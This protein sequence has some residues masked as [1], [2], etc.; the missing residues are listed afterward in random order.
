MTRILRF[1]LLFAACGPNAASECQQIK[2]RICNHG[3]E[4]G[5]EQDGVTCQ[6][7]F[8]ETY[9]CDPEATLE[10]L[11]LCSDAALTLECPRSIPFVCYDVLCDADL[12]CTDDPLTPT[13]D[14]S[15]TSSV[16]R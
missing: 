12:G 15:D 3:V 14:T 7:E 1:G 11:Q 10:E 5:I 8:D 13:T 4:C 16:E 6:R 2:I 9:I